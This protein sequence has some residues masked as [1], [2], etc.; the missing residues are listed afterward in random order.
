MGRGR[1]GGSRCRISRFRRGSLSSS[2]WSSMSAP[3]FLF[4]LG[5]FRAPKERY[6][7]LSREPCPTSLAPTLVHPI[8]G[9]STA[10][11]LADLVASPTFRS[12]VHRVFPLS[13][14]RV[15]PYSRAPSSSLPAAAGTKKSFKDDDLPHKTLIMSILNV[16]PD[17]FSDGDAARA[18]ETEVALAQVREHVELGAD[19]VDIGGM[20]TRP[21]ADDITSSEE[22]ARVVPV[23]QA[24][25]AS[26]SSPNLN[27]T[28]I[29]IDTFR[30]SVARAAIEAGADVI[31]DVYGGREPGMLE[32]MADLA[33]PVILMHSRGTPSTMTSLTDY[34]SADGGLVEGVR[35]E[36]VQMVEEAL[37]AR[38][39][40]WNIILDP[41]FGFAKTG[42]QNLVLLRSLDK[43]FSSSEDSD[44]DSGHGTT[45]NE[46]PV[47]IGLSR[48]KFLAPDKKVAKERRLE[49]A[50]AVACAIASGRCEIARVHDT[51]DARD[52]VAF[53]DRLLNSKE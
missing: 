1:R 14:S 41:G 37:A 19:I 5:S 49:T 15:H 2:L 8:L 6:A 36:M 50:A 9:K 7:D 21:F 46:Y 30:P 40:R 10:Q 24:I 16:T 51:A 11:L 32:T 34:S 48:K 12:T 44:S 23:V 39:R 53:G 26:S 29:S 18:T 47:L 22:Q 27:E 33:C 17:S 13:Q 52:V 3:S 31:N 45:L 43:L 20:S 28:V 25:R 4:Q 42:E 35:R 38:V